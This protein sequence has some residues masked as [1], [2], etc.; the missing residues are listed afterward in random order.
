M[1]LAT[2]AVLGDRGNGLERRLTSF[3][4]KR[5]ELLRALRFVL[6]VRDLLGIFLL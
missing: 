4:A 5:L 6:L 1:E 3:A 2:G